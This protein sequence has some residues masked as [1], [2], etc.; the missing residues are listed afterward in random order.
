MCRLGG[1]AARGRAGFF[2]WLN[3]ALGL[4]VL[5]TV[6][7]VAAG[8]GGARTGGITWQAPKNT[9]LAATFS[10]ARR[11]YKLHGSAT[12]QDNS[13]HNGNTAAKSAVVFGYNITAAY[14]V[15]TRTATETVTT[16]ATQPPFDQPL[17]YTG[18]YTCSADPWLDNKAANCKVV[19]RNGALV[20]YLDGAHLPLG[21]AVI[22]AAQAKTL[23]AKAKA[24]ADILDIV[25]PKE[26][27]TYSGTNDVLFVIKQHA[28]ADLGLANAGKI[29]L[30]GEQPGNPSAKFTHTFTPAANPHVWMKSLKL[31]P[32][33]WRV[34][35]YLF[36]NGAAAPADAPQR[37]FT[38]AN[39]TVA[40]KPSQPASEITVRSPTN[41]QVVAAGEP[42]AIYIRLAQ[43]LVKPGDNTSG[44]VKVDL[45]HSVPTAPGGWPKP[46]VSIFSHAYPVTGTD[47][48][49]SIP[50]H[51]RSPQGRYYL[52]AIFFPQGSS[53]PGPA[54][55]VGFYY[56]RVPKRAVPNLMDTKPTLHPASRA[57]GTASTPKAAPGK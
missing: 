57:V 49:L 35:A 10:A 3:V 33:A 13:H 40:V 2:V 19:A 4:F 30:A 39:Q 21:A 36:A 26:G 51:P 7:A 6:T 56:G 20:K 44:V 38:V 42:V 37:H 31:A 43:H 14:N 1:L 48:Q 41:N 46:P 5:G 11:D 28:P 25:E 8:P 23:L 47:M 54:T 34:T 45:L 16:T 27:Q 18:R 15:Q 55:M 53:K 9:D 52:D 50:M 32:G 22:G 17:T 24:A 12:Y 29:V